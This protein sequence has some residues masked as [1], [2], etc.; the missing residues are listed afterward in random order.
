MSD[1]FGPV[2][3]LDA[4]RDGALAP[5]LSP[6]GLLEVAP[7]ERLVLPSPNGSAISAALADA[8]P[9]V[10]VGCLRNAR[11][12]A[13]WLAPTLDEGRSVAVAAQVDASDAVPVLRDGAFGAAPGPGRAG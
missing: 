11:A 13:A 10:V 5:S 2:G 6:G 3:R 8:G 1:V 7:V 4:V 9:T 12:V